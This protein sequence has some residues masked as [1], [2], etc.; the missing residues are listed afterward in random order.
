MTLKLF[1]L[2]SKESCKLHP[3]LF[4]MDFV[5]KINLF[6]VI[7]LETRIKYIAR[8][9]YN[10]NLLLVKLSLNF[11]QIFSNLVEIRK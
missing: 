7:S 2:V 9:I 5:T 10:G 6:C 11:C 3:K 1:M 8:V 4:L